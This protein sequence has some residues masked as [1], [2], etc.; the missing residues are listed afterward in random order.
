MFTEYF[1]PL[2]RLLIEEA[3]GAITRVLLPN[4]EDVDTAAPIVP[5]STTPILEAAC[6]QLGEYFAGTRTQ[7][8]LPLAP[9]GTPFMLSVW[10]ALLEIPYGTTVSYKH[11]ATALGNPRAVRAVGMANGRNPIPIIIPCHRV[12]GANGAPVGY[13]GGL[14]IKQQLLSLES[15]ELF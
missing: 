12:I 11:I 15:H 3:H 2:G 8:D 13:T 9:H 1:S 14:H 7:F 6:Q 5:A 10:D 4:D